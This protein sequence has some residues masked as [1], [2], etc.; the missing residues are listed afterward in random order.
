MP[1]PIIGLASVFVN[2]LNARQVWCAT[3]LGKKVSL[4]FV[5]PGA[6]GYLYQEYDVVFQ[7]DGAFPVNWP[8][9]FFARKE[10]WIVVKIR[11]NYLTPKVEKADH[12]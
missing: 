6:A 4:R 3:I 12:D 10:G 9:S 8:D 2:K 1:Q 11:G 7:G 5:T